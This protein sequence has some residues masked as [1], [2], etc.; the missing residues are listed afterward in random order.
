LVLTTR[1]LFPGRN[2]WEN[3]LA[4][5]ATSDRTSE[6]IRQVQALEAAG[7]DV[8][9][10]TADVADAAATKE[11]VETAV[12]HFGTLH[13]VIH[14]AGIAGGGMIQLK[15]A[16]DAQSVLAPKITGTRNLEAAL[17]SHNLD[18]IMLCSSLASVVGGVG[19]VDYCAANAFL[20]AYAAAKNGRN[21]TQ[22][23]SVNWDMWAEVGMAVNTD[24]LGKTSTA[25]S[26]AYEKTLVNHPLLQAKYAINAQETVYEFSLT[27]DDHWVVAE[28]IVMGIPTAPGTMHLEL[29]RAALADKTGNDSC[30]IREA[31]FVLPLMVNK[32]M[33]KAAQVRLTEESDM[34]KFV[35]QSESGVA[36]DGSIQWDVH[37]MG[38]ATAVTPPQPAPFDLPTIIDRCQP[39]DIPPLPKD[40]EAVRQSGILF[41]SRWHS[42]RHAYAGTNEAV[43]EIVLDDALHA[44]LDG[45]KLHPAILDIA[46]SYGISDEFDG[47]YLPLSYTNLAVYKP[48]PPR[49]FSYLRRETA[50]E[51]NQEVMS[52]SVTLLDEEG[53]V[54][55]AIES[56]AVKRVRANAATRLR[57]VPNEDRKVPNEDKGETAVSTRDFSMAILPAEGQALFARILARVRTPQ[58]IVSTRNL[59]GAMAQF[60]QMQENF[61]QQA[62]NLDNT[63]L[64]K[65]ARPELATAFIAPRNKVEQTIATIWANALGVEKVG[66]R[67]NFF[68]LG[69]ESILGIQIIAQL[70]KAGLSATPDQ[71]FQHQTVAE[72]AVAIEP[73]S[74]DES[75]AVLPVTHAQAKQ[76]NAT[77]HEPH[78]VVLRVA[79]ALDT[80]HLKQAVTHIWSHYDAFQ[81]A[82]AQTDD[83]WVTVPAPSPV[84]PQFTVVKQEGYGEEDD[85]QAEMA[86]MRHGFSTSTPPWLRVVY[87]Q[88]AV[89]NHDYLLFTISP[90][91]ADAT[92]VNLLP[93]SLMTAYT[94]LVQGEPVTLPPV[95]TTFSTW[96][97]AW[98]QAQPANATPTPW[99]AIDEN[100]AP[101]QWQQV[102]MMLPPES[103]GRFA[104]LTTNTH[105]Q[106]QELILAAFAQTIHDVTGHSPI[107]LDW[108]Q[109]PP[110]S[111]DTTQTIGART[112]TVPVTL[113]VSPQWDNDALLAETK[114][115]I[116]SVT[117]SDI[118]HNQGSEPS[119]YALTI[120]TAMQSVDGLEPV[121]VQL[122][123]ET[124]VPQIQVVVHQVGTQMCIT[125]TY[126]ARQHQ[127]QEINTAAQSLAN[128]ITQLLDHSLTSNEES[129]IPSDFPDAGLDQMELNQFI[130]KLT[131][132]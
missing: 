98:S 70:R 16:A 5:H 93:Q 105:T 49:V 68:D 44:D 126:D 31:I 100:D 97:Q 103:N 45:Y 66:I 115:Q 20:D 99:P 57:E 63:D 41:G 54:L 52:V 112:L 77:T 62:A 18:F 82:F 37:L 131:K 79:D 108:S 84:E 69:G 76:L 59:Q 71:L 121:Q 53:Q 129:F 123:R 17:V 64:P 104:D 25:S 34:F 12:S 94:Q 43:A 21:G 110:L 81:M 35:V 24:P 78:L 2:T 95:E 13:G 107:Y 6:R 55:V 132:G 73:D 14:A 72:L 1:N 101:Q 109:Q 10:V 36:A 40:T 128:A 88:T 65:H 124:A 92:A 29:V 47:L 15:T 96:L 32:D 74:V 106:P 50:Q 42:M 26:T 91:V 3:W 27:Q 7:A 83:G 87:M 56:F 114:A 120:H 86:R 60:K 80:R 9:I 38:D 116:R 117:L 102:E 111:L 22:V 8:L 33:S 75:L 67:D 48:L 85:L 127:Q 90:L 11:M 58:I 122:V 113:H 61:L 39:H 118:A 89:S 119:P 51:A 23:V 46:T 28:H 19:Q 4:T 30:T 125:W 130:S